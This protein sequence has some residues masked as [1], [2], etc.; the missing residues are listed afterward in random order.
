[1]MW[2]VDSF[3]VC[4]FWIIQRIDRYGVVKAVRNLIEN[5]RSQEER[6]QAVQTER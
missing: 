6:M 4:F 2:F 1:M 5:P 3:G